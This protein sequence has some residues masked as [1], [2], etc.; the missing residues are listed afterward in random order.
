MPATERR[1]HAGE[2]I[3][4]YCRAC[5]TDRMHTIVVTDGHAQPLRVSCG[6]CHSEHNYRGG[7]RVDATGPDRVSRERGDSDRSPSSQRAPSA[8]PVGGSL[9]ARSAKEPFPIVSDREVTMS[10]DAD[11]ELLLR[12]VIREES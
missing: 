1:Y 9:P 5:K 10:A 11:L 3:E 8:S 6:Y 2:T 4:D 12:R 7:P